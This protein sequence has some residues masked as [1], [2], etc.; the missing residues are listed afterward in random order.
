MIKRAY[1]RIVTHDN[2]VVDGP[3]VVV[4]NDELKYIDYHLL[5]GEEPMVE[6]IGGSFKMF[7]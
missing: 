3:V 4:F 5:Q 7:Q 6:W 1:H 2:H